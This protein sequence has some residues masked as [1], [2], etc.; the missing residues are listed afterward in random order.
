MPRPE[1][2]V[3]ENASFTASPID[4]EYLHRNVGGHLERRD[5]GWAVTRLVGHMALPSGTTLRIRSRKST[6]ASLLAWMAF[7]DPA[8]AGLRWFQRVPN[9]AG[10]GDIAALTVRL[11]FTELFEVLARHGVARRYRREATLSPVVRGGIDFAALSRMGGNLSKLPCRVWERLPDTPLNRLVVAAVAIISRDPILRPIFQQDLGRARAAF[12]GIPPIASPEAL[13]GRVAPDRV[14]SAFSTAYALARII[15]RGSLLGDGGTL[16][17]PGFLINLETLFEKTVVRALG[18]AGLPTT[19]K[20]SVPYWRVSERGTETPAGMEADV[21]LHDPV[22]GP[23]VIDAKYKSSIS[24]G[25]LQQLIAYCSVLGARFGVLVVPEGNVVDRRAYHFRIAELGS[26][27]IHVV[28][29]RTAARSVDE[30]RT[31]AAGLVAEL[32]ARIGPS[33]IDGGRTPARLNAACTEKWK[34]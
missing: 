27:R 8:L 24:S 2:E 29:L 30:W 9:V 34:R 16:G 7:V 28:Q 17:A 18:L 10:D 33:A 14:E 21:V 32:R 6:S 23:V 11:F 12:A 26:F 4:L 19:P 25:N 15:V 31:N 22:L 5:T 1:L 13:S 20:A 3:F